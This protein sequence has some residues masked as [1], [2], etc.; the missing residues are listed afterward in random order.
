LSSVVVKSI[1]EG[2]VRRAVD[3]YAADLLATRPN[4]EE[5]VVFGSFERGTFAPGSDVDV[6]IVL[7]SAE[8][9]VRDRVP[10]F[11]PSRFPVPL[12]LFPY[13]RQEL[14]DLAGSPVVAAAAASRW[15][16]R[17]AIDA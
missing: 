16:Y 9:P 3:R 6:L 4:V 13:T 11:L 8:T 5:I 10:D 7:S 15:R 12:D 14:S 2:A 17:R 1:D